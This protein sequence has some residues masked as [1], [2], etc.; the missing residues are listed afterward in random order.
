MRLASSPPMV[1]SSSSFQSASRSLAQR[2]QLGLGQLAHLGVRA[3]R[4]SRWASAICALSSLKRRYFLASLAS[5]PCSRAAAATRAGLASTAG[6]TSCFSSS[7]K[8]ASFSSSIF[9]QRHGVRSSG[10]A[11]RCRGSCEPLRD[12]RRERSALR[13]A[14]ATETPP[15]ARTATRA[16]RRMATQRGYDSVLVSAG[17]LPRFRL[18]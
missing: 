3:R 4:S 6:S 1:M 9:A 15:S 18:A 17:F 5:E 16:R 10:S 13:Q 7:S 8:R 14:Q 11:Q 2:G 12:S